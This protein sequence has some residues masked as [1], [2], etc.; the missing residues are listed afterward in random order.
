MNRSLVSRLVKS[1]A[2]LPLFMGGLAL[3]ANL[4]GCDPEVRDAVLTGF[5]TSVTSLTT[6]LISAFFMSLQD[7]TTATSQ[8]VVQAVFDGLAGLFA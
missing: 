6:S 8:P 5:S 2:F 1:K 3:Q 7:A 4:G